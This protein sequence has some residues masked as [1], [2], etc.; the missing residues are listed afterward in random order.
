MLLL[1][2]SM[3]KKLL[4]QWEMLGREML[5]LS[6]ILCNYCSLSYYSEFSCSNYGCSGNG[7][8]HLNG[9]NQQPSCVCYK[10]WK[11]KKCTEVI[12]YCKLYG[13]PC[14]NGCCLRN[15]TYCVCDGGYKGRQC[16]ISLVDH[17]KHEDSLKI[18]ENCNYVYDNQ[19][20]FCQWYYNTISCSE[21]NMCWEGEGCH[22]LNSYAFKCVCKPGY[23]ELSSCSDDP[24]SF[25]IC[26]ADMVGNSLCE[27]KKYSAKDICPYGR[28]ES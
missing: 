4:K 15:S 24:A 3:C 8:C 20:Y 28:K 7:Y 10:G 25:G 5:L 6:R 21:Y 26:K 27:C 17:C 14:H 16:S 11:G 22:T 12:D 23:W 18:E 13:N 9:A 2:G 1:I 19:T